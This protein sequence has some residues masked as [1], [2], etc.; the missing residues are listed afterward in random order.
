MREALLLLP[1]L[2]G[3]LHAQRIRLNAPLAREVSGDV[4]G[5]QAAH[6]GE[7]VVYATDPWDSGWARLERTSLQHPGAVVDLGASIRLEAYQDSAY[8]ELSP[9]GSRVVYVTVIDGSNLELHATASDGSA[10]AVRLDTAAPDAEGVKSFRI[11][12]DG[13]WVVYAADQEV[14]QRFELFAVPIEGG[15]ARK[16]S[17]PLPPDGDVAFG[18][19]DYVIGPDSRSVFFRASAQ[20]ETVDL[21]RGSVSGRQ[22]VV[23]LNTL[24]APGRAVQEFQLTPDGGRVVYRA[25][26]FVNQRFELFSVPADGSSPP[27]SIHPGLTV[28]ADVLEFQLTASG[29]SVVYKFRPSPGANQLFVAPNDGRSLPRRIGS[30][31]VGAY[32]VDPLGRRVVFLSPPR[33][34]FPLLFSAPLDGS[35]PAV[36]IDLD[37]RPDLAPEGDF[38]ISP[39]G[40]RVVYVEREGFLPA[41]VY[42]TP[43]DAGRPP[44]KIAQLAQSDVAT[45]VGFGADGTRVVFGLTSYLV[46]GPGPPL[47]LGGP[48]VLDSDALGTDQIVAGD[49]LLYRRRR[50]SGELTRT[51]LYRV[52]IDRRLAP[53]Q[54]N[55]PFGPGPA[56]DDVVQFQTA[57]SSDRA[58]YLTRRGEVFGVELDGTP[59]PVRLHA[60]DDPGVYPYRTVLLSPDGRWVVFDEEGAPFAVPFSGEREAEALAPLGYSLSITPDS[61]R[62]LFAVY[63]PAREL[64]S[65]PLDGSSA[66]VRLSGAADFYGNVLVSPDSA[67]V[68]FLSRRA[69]NLLAIHSVPADGSR[70]P[71]DLGA[72]VLDG[73]VWW[74]V[75]FRIQL[76]PDGR[77]VVC[78]GG[79]DA[80]PGR[81]LLSIPVDGSG[82][83]VTLDLLDAGVAWFAFDRSTSSVVYAQLSWV[84][85][86]SPLVS[87]RR[88]PIRGGAPP[89]SLLPP[90]EG[91]I[92]GVFE[93]SSD[94]KCVLFVR[95]FEFLPSEFGAR[96]TYDVFS[97]TADGSQQERRLN[98]QPAGPGWSFAGRHGDLHFGIPVFLGPDGHAV[99]SE[100]EEL[101]S[102]PVDGSAAPVDLIS[103]DADLVDRVLFGSRGRAAVFELPAAE[104]RALHA[105]ATD[106]SRPTR[107]LSGI[108]ATGGDV[109]EFR[110]TAD[111][112]RV[113]YLG[114]LDED[115]ADELFQSFLEHPRRRPA[116]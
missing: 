100:G 63:W 49:F 72:F 29:K 57:A 94:G 76:S 81:R 10:A 47:F 19:T 33:P 41:S 52:P 95:D 116:R 17:G 28:V 107:L 92:P 58:A 60:G 24:H 42:G 8:F 35:S 39:D 59:A 66:A 88:V 11:S 109:H 110:V 86:E 98:T 111:G 50:S 14:A 20:P 30:D 96:F 83:P 61:R 13:Q 27:V 55:P 108:P 105:A 80:E 74:T 75:P 97:V 112:A 22:P 5:H 91:G 56:V 89:L 71:V 2:C 34:G 79:T 9:N 48:E 87:L 15:E 104:G 1:F 23:R 67:H 37:D 36:R 54:V 84:F 3:P 64:F 68:V 4:L 78:S 21:Y 7:F 62:L 6:R 90:F 46:D 77:D 32:R 40:G 25:D 43:I 73:N 45:F 12:A 113:V 26:T 44:V 99:F 82:P 18:W 51:D 106:A 102:A 114:D 101:E 103:G 16:V 70:P 93:L 85:G 69:D 53:A 38:R 65:V 115:G 31:N